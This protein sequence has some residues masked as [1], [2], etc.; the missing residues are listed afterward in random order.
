MFRCACTFNTFSN[1]NPMNT[2]TYQDMYASIG[3]LFYGIA[4]SDGRIAKAEGQKLKEEV[5]KHW[6]PLENSRD[7]FG[8]DAAHYIVISFD[9]ANGQE[10][11]AEEAF[12]KFLD[13]YQQEPARYDHTMKEL[14]LKTASAIASSFAGKNKAELV[15]L[16]RLQVAF[17]A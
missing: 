5:T 6:L 16:S 12:T 2:T 15:R 3:Y 4:A 14:I 9:Y 13:D 8:T 10:M 7:E 17:S 1:N 11:D